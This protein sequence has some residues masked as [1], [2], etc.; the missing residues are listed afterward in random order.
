[1]KLDIIK[2]HG[3]G[4]D[5]F[6]VDEITTGYTF[7]ET[8]R[9]DLAKLICNRET[10]LG[11]DGVLFIMESGHADGK[12]RVFNADGSEA[13]MCGNGLRLAARYICELKGLDHAVVE[14]MKADLKVSKYQELYPDIHTYQVEISPVLFDLGA[15]PLNL[16]QP[17]LLNEPIHQL[18]ET[19]RFTA[20]AVPNPHLITLVDKAILNS[21]TQKRLSEK[22][23][24]PNRLFPYG[25]NVSFV[26]VLEPGEIYVRTF[27][28]GVGFTNACGTAMSASSLVTCLQGLNRFESAIDVY[29]NGGKVKCIVHQQGEDY[30]IDLIGNATYLYNASITADLVKG[31]FT[32][33]AKTGLA[34]QGSY[35][36]LQLEVQEYLDEYLKG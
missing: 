5:F 19:L 33:S 10:E 12:M 23:N 7:T 3:S 2:G 16:P 6:L 18:S 8:E 11:A 26:K 14:T 15:L 25:V 34:E 31:T 21:H 24:G 17:V 20:V 29:N 36:K 22:V 30:S 32:V 13:S 1:M 9:A 28:R 35:Q 4:N 27:E